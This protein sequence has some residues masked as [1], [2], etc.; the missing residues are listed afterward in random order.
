MRS[1]AVIRVGEGETLALGVTE[2]SVLGVSLGAD[3]EADG[4]T[5][6]RAAFS[7]LCPVQAARTIIDVTT[8]DMTVSF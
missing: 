8:A 6:G 3:A 5:E 1:S 2:G 7:P 4:V